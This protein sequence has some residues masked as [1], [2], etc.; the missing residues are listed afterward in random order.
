MRAYDYLRTLCVFVAVGMVAAC[1]K[2]APPAYDNVKAIIVDG[3]KLTAK[4][5]VDRYCVNS[6]AEV[7]KHERCVAAR[8]EAT[9]EVTLDA[10]RLNDKEAELK[11]LNESMG[12]K[13]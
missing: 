13:P 2:N 4:E 7:A 1:S 3:Q 6:S 11:R 5:Y 12:I 8:G 10:L 9:R